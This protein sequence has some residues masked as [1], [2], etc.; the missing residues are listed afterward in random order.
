MT[1]VNVVAVE[2][3]CLRGEQPLDEVRVRIGEV[4]TK[5]KGTA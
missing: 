3:S 4:H 5:Q 2:F 1:F